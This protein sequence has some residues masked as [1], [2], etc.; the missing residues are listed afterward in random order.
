ME[1]MKLAGIVLTTAVVVQLLPLLFRKKLPVVGSGY[2][3]PGW[4][5]VAEVF[6]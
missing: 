1:L 4:E 3:A 6:R 2:T 5:K